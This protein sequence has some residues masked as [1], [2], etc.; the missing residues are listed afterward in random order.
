MIA[1]KLIDPEWTAKNARTAIE[2]AEHAERD[3]NTIRTKT[4]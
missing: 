2:T 3:I 1:P 4:G